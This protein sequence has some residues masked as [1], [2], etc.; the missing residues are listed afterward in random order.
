MVVS[1]ARL[2]ASRMVVEVARPVIIIE[3]IGPGTL[4][5]TIPIPCITGMIGERAALSSKL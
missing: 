4:R 2:L 1:G 5:D 3:P